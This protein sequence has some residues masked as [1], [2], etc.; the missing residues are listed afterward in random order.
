VRVSYFGAVAL[1]FAMASG[2]Y[3]AGAAAD[4]T[5]VSVLLQTN[6]IVVAEDGSSVQTV[7]SELHADNDAGAMRLG[8]VQVGFN[9]GRQDLQIV[10]AYTLKPD[11]TKLP[12]D[13][14][15]IYVRLPQDDANEGMVTDQRVKVIIFPQ[16]AAG[17]TAVYTAKIINSKP[18]FPGIFTYGQAFSPSSPVKEVRDSITAP[19]DMNLR[20]ETHDIDFKSE[21]HGG[22]VTYRWHYSSPTARATPDAEV[23]PMDLMPRYFASNFKD[24]AELGRAYQTVAGPKIAVTPKVAALADKLT[25]GVSDP[26]E[27]TRKLYEWMASHVRYIAIELGQGTIVPHDVDDILT[28]GYGDCKDHDTLMR[29]LLKAKGIDSQSVLLN[30]SNAYTLTQVPTFSQLDHVITYVPGM[31]LFLDSSTVTTPFGVLPYSEYGKPVVYVSA[32]GATQ[33]ILPVLTPGVATE[34]TTNVMKL[35]ATGIL[36]GTTTTTAVGP[37]EILMRLIGLAMQAVS[38]AKIASEQL[39]ARGYAGGTG[40]LRAGP[41][42]VPGS[43][44]TITGDFSVPGWAEW[45][46]GRKVSFMPIGLR[47]LGVTGDGPMGSISSISSN[48]MSPTPCYSVHQSEDDSLE[49]PANT[50]F[51]AIP[52]DAQVSTDNVKFTAHW[53]VAGRVLSVHREFNSKIDQPLCTGAVRRQAARALLEIAI[54]YL[55]QIRII[56]DTGAPAVVSQNALPTIG[57]KPVGGHDQIAFNNTLTAARL[58]D[59][60]HAGQVVGA[61]LASNHTDAPDHSFSMH[62]AQ[63][64]AF[65]KSSQLA[66][67]VAEL[68]EAI[69]LNP[70]A[71]SEPYSAR[72]S[73]YAKMGKNKLAMADLNTAL[74]SAPDDADL[75]RAHADVL[76]QMKDYDGAAADYNVIVKAH[77]DDAAVVLARAGIRYH[78]DKYDEAS[79]DYRRAA[80]LGA[81]DQDVRPGLCN[82]LARTDE[83]AAAVAPC[84]WT[85]ARDPQSGAGLE[86]RGYASFR[87]GK[88]ADALAD[89]AQA[90][91][92]SPQNARY[93]Y[94]VGVTRVKAGKAAEG[95]QDM[96]A[97]VKLDARIARKVPQKLAL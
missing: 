39:E 79:A 45:L 46:S 71:G 20:T 42:M 67:A 60:D 96:N 5:P 22:T 31:K 92:A 33:G 37:S 4:V 10:D 16:M 15:A 50:R 47:I 97:A 32:A 23:S 64:L 35:S 7:H 11:G 29:A 24:Y 95:R 84:S 57:P 86:S 30:S 34:R 49:I 43:S 76:V 82:A 44:Y 63:G 52:P 21:D 94:E 38:P 81:S 91:K 36:T 89:F 73:A 40:T 74:K 80:K 61:L 17:D 6:D 18:I 27:Q 75:R 53:T 26:R 3:A 8:Q 85:L 88:Y 12:V 2:A 41:P 90:A 1:S 25:A 28:Y 65:L 56:P 72:A 93:L 66:E 48:D 87:L 59:A 58:G 51:A 83:F 70:D 54:S 19:K 69:R 68:S 62:L 77:P 78:A 14:S 55:G 13:T 9:T